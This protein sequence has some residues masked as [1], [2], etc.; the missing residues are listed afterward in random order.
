[1]IVNPS[2]WSW[3][4]KVWRKMETGKCRARYNL[5]CE[6]RRYMPTNFILSARIDILSQNFYVNFLQEYRSYSRRV[7]GYV[8][9]LQFNIRR[10]YRHQLYYKEGSEWIFNRV[11]YQQQSEDNSHNQ[12]R[13]DRFR[14]TGVCSPSQRQEHTRKPICKGQSVHT[15]APFIIDIILYGTTF[16]FLFHVYVYVRIKFYYLNHWFLLQAEKLLI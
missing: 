4:S 10:R 8:A 2:Q 1:M 7:G 12:C 14:H 15:F 9:C 5:T 3:C 11:F 16:C 13:D 6:G